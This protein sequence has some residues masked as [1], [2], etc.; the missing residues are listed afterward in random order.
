[1][2]VL[3]VYLPSNH[4]LLTPIV[5]L[6]NSMSGTNKAFNQTFFFIL[7]LLM[8][9]LLVVCFCSAGDQTSGLAHAR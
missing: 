1:M 5:S 6:C 3:Y 9:L 8:V 7:L 4:K 2:V